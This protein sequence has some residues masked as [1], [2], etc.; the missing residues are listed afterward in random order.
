MLKLTLLSIFSFILA[1]AACQDETSQDQKCDSDV[2]ELDAG[3][4]AGTQAGQNP[5]PAG[6]TQMQ[7]IDFT[8]MGTDSDP[9]GGSQDME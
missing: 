2:E 8:D 5:V 4:Q 3:V 7:F 1:F 9:E 6:Q